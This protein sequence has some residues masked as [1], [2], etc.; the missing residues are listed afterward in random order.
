MPEL[1]N[2]VLRRLQHAARSAQQ[3]AIAQRDLRS[4]D[5]HT[6]RD[7]GLSHRAAAE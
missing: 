1:I 2:R 7:I 5:E 6:L 4:L 3:R